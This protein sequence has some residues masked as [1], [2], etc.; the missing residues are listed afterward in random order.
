VKVEKTTV[1]LNCHLLNTA[2]SEK[3]YT[4]VAMDSGKTNMKCQ[5]K[6]VNSESNFTRSEGN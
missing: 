2:G 3:F 5:K 1:T 6:F 4:L